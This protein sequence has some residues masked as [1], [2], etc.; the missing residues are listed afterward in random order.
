MFQCNRSTHIQISDDVYSV[1]RLNSI[2]TEHPS[3]GVTCRHIL[4]IVIL[5]KKINSK[6]SIFYQ[7]PNKQ[8]DP[9]Q[10]KEF[11]CDTGKAEVAVL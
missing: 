2:C 5:N 7:R 6:Y 4:F 11:E 1:F 3:T 9:R 10:G 8:K